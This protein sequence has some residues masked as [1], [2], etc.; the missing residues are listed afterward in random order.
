MQIGLIFGRL[1]EV[2]L[3]DGS[4]RTGGHSDNDAA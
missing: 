4:N 2:D 1:V 3:A